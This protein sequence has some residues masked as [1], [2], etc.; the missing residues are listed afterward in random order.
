[1]SLLPT[2][3]PYL[4]QIIAAALPCATSGLL[5]A[6]CV[7]ALSRLPLLNI[8]ALAAACTCLGALLS[9]G[10]GEIEAGMQMVAAGAVSAGIL[11]LSG[12]QLWRRPS[13]RRGALDRAGELPPDLG[14]R[15]GGLP[16][17]LFRAV[18]VIAIALAAGELA[19]VIPLGIP[20]ADMRL[21]LWLA[22]MG[23]FAG[24]SCGNAMVSAT[25]YLLA[26]SAAT[27][28]IPVLVPDI[29]QQPMAYAVIPA[30]LIVAALGFSFAA[31]MRKP[32]TTKTRRRGGRTVNAD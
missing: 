4:T 2:I 28:L 23:L 30:L 32:Q 6:S 25:G 18:A 27:L 31:T 7:I 8:V 13:L 5:I 16:D 17:L 14:G 12:G 22:G 26:A 29:T 19:P 20:V 11:L 3:E 10:A 15:G 21:A 9:T 1:M 24:L